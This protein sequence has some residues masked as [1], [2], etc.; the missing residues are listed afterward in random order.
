MWRSEEEGTSR[1]ISRLVEF[2]TL[3][4]TN[5]QFVELDLLSLASLVEAHLIV[6]N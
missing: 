4:R 3:K 6:P 5:L 2:V 1:R